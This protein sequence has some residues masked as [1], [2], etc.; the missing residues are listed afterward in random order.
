[1]VSATADSCVEEARQHLAKGESK[2]AV[3]ELKNALQADPSVEARLMLGL[4]CWAMMVR[5]GQGI[6]TRP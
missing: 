4:Y 1:M 3:I 6:R 5:G 2:A